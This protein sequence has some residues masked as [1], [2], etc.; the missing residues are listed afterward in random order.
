MPSMIPVSK[1]VKTRPT[2]VTMKG[3]NCQNP[4]LHIALNN[5]TRASR[6]P[7]TSKMA[8][9]LASGISLSRAGIEATQIRSRTP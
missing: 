2:I 1:S 6:Y 3:M 7:I 4:S 8:A 5:D 9:R